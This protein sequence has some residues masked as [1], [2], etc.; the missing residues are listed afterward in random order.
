V[1]GSLTAAALCPAADQRHAHGKPGCQP[2]GRRVSPCHADTVGG[3]VTDQ[4]V[5]TP[6]SAPPQTDGSSHRVAIRG[7]TRADSLPVRESE[8]QVRRHRWNTQGDV[9]VWNVALGVSQNGRRWP[10]F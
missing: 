8:P 7:N 1:P 9:P 10:G 5:E 3:W 4:M 2:R 6:E